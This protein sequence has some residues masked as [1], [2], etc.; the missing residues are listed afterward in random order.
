MARRVFGA[1]LTIGTSV[2]ALAGHAHGQIWP[3]PVVNHTAPGGPGFNVS[4]AHF[5]VACVLSTPYSGAQ[6]ASIPPG[7]MQVVAHY[8]GNVVGSGARLDIEMRNAA[9]S[10]CTFPLILNA[11]GV[12]FAREYSMLW[13]MEPTGRVKV[14]NV[15]PN[16]AIDGIAFGIYVHNL[17]GQRYMIKSGAQ[18]IAGGQPNFMGA[19]PVSWTEANWDTALTSGTN[20][21]IFSTS[22]DTRRFAQTILASAQMLPN[23]AH[24]TPSSAANLVGDLNHDGCVDI[25]DLAIITS[26]ALPMCATFSGPWTGAPETY[27]SDRFSAMPL[28]RAQIVAY[29]DAST[30]NVTLDIEVRHPTTLDCRTLTFNL[31]TS[32][33]AWIEQYNLLGYEP[34]GRVDVN[35]VSASGG[36]GVAFGIYFR[37]TLGDRWILQST[38]VSSGAPDFIGG[39]PFGWTEAN[40][41]ALITP[42]GLPFTA[43]TFDGFVVR[44]QA[45]NTLQGAQLFQD[46]SYQ[47]VNRRQADPDLDADGDVDAFDV[48]ILMGNL[49]T[50]CCP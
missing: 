34:T 13:G 4:N 9:G 49:G 30:A 27:S 3:G 33:Q 17:A 38:Q 35:G 36:N 16:G 12:V 8:D 23:G 26:G 7:R 24:Y 48:A 43:A 5:T 21:A 40:W 41:D 11:N 47:V 28:G 22:L 10:R 39:W 19:W 25:L 18:G 14:S 32:T 46:G 31:P 37:N 1:W 50:G 15:A 6:P 45:Q 44:R 20:P 2:L 42:Y 29:S